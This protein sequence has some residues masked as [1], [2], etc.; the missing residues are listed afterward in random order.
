MEENN[1]NYPLSETSGRRSRP[2]KL[3]LE[4]VFRK[5][6]RTKIAQTSPLV[7]S[8]MPLLFPSPDSNNKTLR[9]LIHSTSLELSPLESGTKLYKVR[10]NGRIRGLSWYKRMYKLNLEY[11]NLG[12]MTYISKKGKMKYDRIENA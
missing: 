5:M 12:D 11:G 7:I 1:E 8:N 9:E 6:S 4:D 2:L 10:Y 3:N